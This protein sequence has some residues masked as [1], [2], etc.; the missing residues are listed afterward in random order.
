MKKILIGLI[1]IIVIIGGSG[2]AWYKSAYGGTSYYVKI[3]ADGKKTESRD[4]AGRI[5]YRYEYNQKA[6]DKAGVEKQIEFTA[7]HNLRHDAY[8]DLTYNKTK[9]VTTWNEVQK[10]DLPVKVEA[11]LN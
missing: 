11:K 1:V 6:Y 2:Y 8:L 5:Y 4:D 7:D 3:T 10:S 9:G